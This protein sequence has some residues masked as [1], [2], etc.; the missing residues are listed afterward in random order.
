MR[1]T[2]S[3]CLALSVLTFPVTGAAQVTEQGQEIEAP[4]A[5]I[6]PLME[7]GPEVETQPMNALAD[8]VAEPDPAP[9]AM[10]APGREIG[11]PFMDT[12]EVARPEPDVTI[13]VDTIDAPT[14]EDSP[15]EAVGVGDG[16]IP[17]RCPIDRIRTAYQN[18]V[19]PDDALMALAIEKQTLAICRQSQ[20]ALIQ[21]AENEMRLRELFEPIMAPSIP[22]PPA[23]PEAPIAQIFSPE[24]ARNVTETLPIDPPEG[25]EPA[26]EIM[27]IEIEIPPPPR[28]DFTLAAL[29]RDPEGRKAILQRGQDMYTVR[30]G[31]QI[32]ENNRLVRIDDTSVT[33][34]DEND[35]EFIL[36]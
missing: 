12:V 35:N 36:E 9:P 2:I 15:S 4:L 11:I 21:I 33:I 30:E 13:S 27:D 31:D 18:L 16:V 22:Q 28:T 10:T 7:Q 24:P 19:D 8:S 34:A 20:E 25:V 5:D 29:M 1:K 32:D 14:R 23:I 6:A 26:E 17:F 3:L